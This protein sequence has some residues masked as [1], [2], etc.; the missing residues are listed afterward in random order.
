MKTTRFLNII[1]PVVIGL[2]MALPVA[3]D[4]GP[5]HWTD[6]SSVLTRRTNRP[7][8]TMAYASDNWFY[9][10]GQDLWNGGQVY[11]SD[12]KTQSNITQAIRTSG[13]NRVDDIVSD[14][15][16]ILFLQDVVSHNNSFSVLKW[17]GS[18][19][20]ISNVLRPS[21]TAD[22]GVSSIAGRNDTWYI[23]TTNGRV[24][25]WD[26]LHTPQQVALPDNIQ[27][28]FSTSAYNMTYQPG[29]VGFNGM[30]MLPIASNNW[31][32]MAY[33]NGNWFTSVYNGN[34]FT[35]VTT[36]VF[37]FSRGT[38][39]LVSNG[40]AV[41]YSN[42]SFRPQSGGFAWYDG[43]T[44][45]GVIASPNI[46]NFAS[47]RTGVWDG[48]YW[49]LLTDQK[50]IL[51]VDPSSAT[52]NYQDLGGTRDYFVAGASDGKGT[53]LLGGAVSQKGIYAP[54]NPLTAKLVRITDNAVRN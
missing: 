24:L 9:S 33:A 38:S 2:S 48:R 1:A 47:V 4:T 51:L 40:A 28:N 17:D 12:G 45:K 43:S 21:F 15:R 37:P 41:L 32:L 7:V 19:T 13:L 26:G 14:G 53:I 44:M 27:Q 30:K 42:P 6:T 36:T 29:Q 22:E 16:S 25:H 46:S 50:H 20:N 11:S 18:M 8:W 23:I 52:M 35:D 10:D 49:M 34:T 39:F 31:L 5:F 3:A 54:T